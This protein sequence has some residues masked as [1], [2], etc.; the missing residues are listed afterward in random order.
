MTFGD[1]LGQSELVL[2]NIGA[3]WCQPCVEESETLDTEIFRPFCSRGLRVVQVV[4]QDED[5]RPST[6]LFCNRWKQRFEMVKNSSM[7]K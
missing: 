3:G 6:S 1:I 5:S 2:F 4:F 7:P